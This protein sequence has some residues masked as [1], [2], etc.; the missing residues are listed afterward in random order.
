MKATAYFLMIWICL[1]NAA[2]AVADL[3]AAAANN[4]NCEGSC[5]SEKDPSPA[6][7]KQKQDCTD[8]CC[9]NGICTPSNCCVCCF[10][11]PE[12]VLSLGFLETKKKIVPFVHENES[13]HSAYLS[14]NW[15]PPKSV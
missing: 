11:I 9:D 15:Q 8:N 7:D 3:Y 1:L 12:R 6:E 14:R 10:Y 5:C 4:E 2:P 13:A